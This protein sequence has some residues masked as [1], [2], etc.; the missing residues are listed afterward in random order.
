MARLDAL[1]GQSDAG[2]RDTLAAPPGAPLLD[3]QSVS[4]RFP[5]A[6]GQPLAVLEDVS[7]HVASG[8]FVALVG[9]SGSGKTTLLSIIAGLLEEPTAGTVSLKGDPTSSRLGR[10][11]YMPQRDLLLP[12]RGALDNAI[13][14]LEAQGVPRQD[15]R[16]RARAL[17]QEFGLAD[18]EQVY[19]AALSGG[20]R[21]RVAFARTIL[22]ARD[23]VLLDEPFG[24]LDAL[25]RAS[26][27][28]WLADLWGRLGVT[29]LLVTHDLDEALFLADRVYALSARPG[30]I[31]LE[32]A[33]PLPRPRR[34]TM[35]ADPAIAAL[36]A[37][38]LA[39]LVDDGEGV[40]G[41]GGVA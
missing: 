21:Q 12:W 33:S 1:P 14:G 5:R 2:P 29:C 18:F 10:V 32:R 26:L 25:T 13:A 31:K 35:L 9:P 23:L 36:K 41:E 40:S 27:Q 24:A 8:E 20:M 38:L 34:L 3:V 15:A 4:L 11:G 28:R 37:E 17:F 39:A 7:L 22:V 30:H 6:A 16:R 19:P